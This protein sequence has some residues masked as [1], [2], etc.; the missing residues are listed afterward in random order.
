MCRVPKQMAP[1]AMVTV[2]A[3]KM[4]RAAAAATVLVASGMAPHATGAQR[5]ITVPR[6]QTNAQAAGATSVPVMAY[7]P[8]VCVGQVF[9]HVTELIL[10]VIGRVPIH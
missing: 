7:V 8:R 10:L 1:Y 2:P 3:N 5:A 9:V 4:P 6:V